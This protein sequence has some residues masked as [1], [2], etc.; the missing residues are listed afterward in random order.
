MKTPIRF[1]SMLAL[2][3]STQCSYSAT[4]PVPSSSDPRIGTVKY[5]QSDVTVI[6]VQRGT[7][8]R[9]VLGADE[10]ILAERTAT[11]FPADCSKAELEWCIHARP[12]A[13]ELLVKPSEGATHNNLEMSTN[14]RDYSFAFDVLPD[15]DSN[16]VARTSSLRALPMFRVVFDYPRTE[17]TANVTAKRINTAG[18]ATVPYAGAGQYGQA[19]R[20]NWE[21]TLQQGPQSDN[22]LPSLVFDDGTFTYFRFPFSR[23]LPTIYAVSP[24]GEE[25]RVNFHVDGD[26]ASLVVVQRT[27][28]RFILR[29]GTA[30]VGI[31][32]EAPAA[33]GQPPV[34]GTTVPGL[35][36]IMREIVQ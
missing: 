14:L 15:P 34:N 31:W 20:L 6:K 28:R 17:Q 1:A 5:N 21:Y 10:K 19:K 11:G 12:G 24:K 32:N 35:A 25:G 18:S 27:G 22:I 3:L 4:V 13:N 36:R 23:E 8:T 26:D 2:F 29:S 33:D 7:V 16:R 30:A 9:I